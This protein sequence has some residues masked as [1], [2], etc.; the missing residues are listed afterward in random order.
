MTPRTYTVQPRAEYLHPSEG[1]HATLLREHFDI[2][3]DD[4][5]VVRS[6]ICPSIVDAYCDH[7]NS[8]S[9]NGEWA[10]FVINN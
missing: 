6:A 7:M 8:C 9:A 1:A 4:G 2:V 5:K 10:E 3:R